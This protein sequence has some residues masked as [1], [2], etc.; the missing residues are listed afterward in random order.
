MPAAR[1]TGKVERHALLYPVKPGCGLAAA[2]L[3][4]R[5]DE[6]AAGEPDG[7]VAASTIFLRGETL[8]RMV[9]MRVPLQEDPVLAVGV[10][11][12]RTAAVL[13][14]L[15]EVPDTTALTTPEGLRHFLA[16]CDMDLITDRR[17]PD[18]S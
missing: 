18:E 6:L 8:V 14:R 4:A 15:I 13:D 2:R 10:N 11:G 9:D 3:L 7:P 17:S 1:D 16:D 5:H 12:P